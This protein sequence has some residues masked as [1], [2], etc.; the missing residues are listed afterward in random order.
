MEYVA[1]VRAGEI[2]HQQRG[3]AQIRQGAYIAAA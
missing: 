2:V 1:R 3:D